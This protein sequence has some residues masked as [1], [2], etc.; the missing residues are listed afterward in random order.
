MKNRKKTRVANIRKEIDAILNNKETKSTKNTGSYPNCNEP[1]IFSVYPTTVYP[2]D[3]VLIKGCKFRSDEGLVLISGDRINLINESWSNDTIIATLPRLRGF[4][5]PYHIVL[6]VQTAKKEMSKPSQK[7]LLNP[8]MGF[9]F[10]D[11]RDIVSISVDPQKCY[12]S[13]ESDINSG[14][15]FMGHSYFLA[16]MIQHA[17]MEL[18]LLLKI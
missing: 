3:P 6:E 11:N 18:I 5:D 12:Y 1:T 9:L 10:L 14:V 13:G 16:L 8:N 15:F 2:G 17:P 7:I 4:A